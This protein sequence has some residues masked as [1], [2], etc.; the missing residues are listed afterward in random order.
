MALQGFGHSESLQRS[1]SLKSYIYPKNTVFL[2]FLLSFLQYPF[3]FVQR[4]YPRTLRI[5]RQLAKC[6]SSMQLCVVSCLAVCGTESSYYRINKQ[7]KYN[8]PL[9]LHGLWRASHGSEFINSFFPVRDGWM[10][11][12]WQQWSPAE[13]EEVRVKPWVCLLRVGYREDFVPVVGRVWA[14]GDH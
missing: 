5:P 14:Q 2:L 11:G 4:L 6:F 12:C 1:C 9:H 3:N 8:I 7:L 13:E 10:R